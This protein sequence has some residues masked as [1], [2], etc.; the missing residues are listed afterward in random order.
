MTRIPS[1]VLCLGL[2]C[3][4]PTARASA[5]P[6]RITDGTIVVTGPFEIGS[7]SIVGTQGFSV[8]GNVD[9]GE[10]RVDPFTQCSPCLPGAM[11]SVGAFLSGV[12]FNADGMLNGNSFHLGDGIDDP[13]SLALEFFGTAIAPLL[14]SLPTSVTV[15]F[16]AQ[17]Q[18]FLPMGGFTIEGGGL[19]TL[20]FERDVDPS[21]SFVDRVRYD[22][23]DQHPI[24]EPATMTLVAGG[25]LGI[26]RAARKQRQKNGH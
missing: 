20:L 6:I 11:I 22:F 17:G 4:A 16:T 3:L 24:P 12:A 14:P 7:V 8:A 23:N 10:G 2:L 5:E 13:E 25:L 1:F 18:L 9:P 15:P 26:V 21:V 19:A